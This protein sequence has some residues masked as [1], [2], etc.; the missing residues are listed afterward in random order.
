[1]QS[2]V[3]LVLALL[4]LLA[5]D[6]EVASSM[7][8]GQFAYQGFGAA[9]L[10]LDDAIVTPS[11][12]LM[13]AQTKCHAFHPTPLSFH[14][15]STATMNTTVVARSFSTSFVFAIVGKYDGLSSYGLAFVIAPTTNLSTMNSGP[16]MGLLNT[17]NGTVNNHVLAVE[18]DTIMN[19]EF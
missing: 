17:T 12:L 14:K 16:Y 11:G 7:D 10:M 19:T 9:R 3:A 13:L 2:M 8:D 5:L 18:L 15:N 6:G 4:L 1:M